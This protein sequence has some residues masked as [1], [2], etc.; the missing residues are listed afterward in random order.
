M[1]RT[2]HQ[3]CLKFHAHFISSAHA[4]VD[5]RQC[6]SLNFVRLKLVFCDIAKCTSFSA[7]LHIFFLWTKQ[8]HQFLVRV[9]RQHHVLIYIL[10]FFVFFIIII[11]LT[12]SN[13]INF[14]IEDIMNW[15]SV[16]ATDMSDDAWVDSHANDATVSDF[17]LRARSLE[18]NI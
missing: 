13:Y 16:P 6:S 11:P 2:A 7:S 18:T 3:R 5:T 8:L 9:C 12:N 1:N 4:T 17:I 10:L 14:L 15:S